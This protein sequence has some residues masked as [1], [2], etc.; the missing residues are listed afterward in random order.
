ML[1]DFNND[2]IDVG[3]D[4]DDLLCLDKV[5]SNL[6]DICNSGFDFA[7]LKVSDLDATIVSTSLN[8]LLSNGIIFIFS[9]SDTK[10]E[11]AIDSKDFS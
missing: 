2:A 1:F 10:T 3:V 8:L 5:F 4:A 11:N 6:D 9:N 7:R